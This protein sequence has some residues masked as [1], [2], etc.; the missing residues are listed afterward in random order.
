MC[1]SR[2]T[3]EEKGG[4]LKKKINYKN[5]LLIRNFGKIKDDYLPIYI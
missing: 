1:V 3:M 5:S 2:S 4:F